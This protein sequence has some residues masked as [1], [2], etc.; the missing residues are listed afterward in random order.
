MIERIALATDP[1]FSVLL[2][3]PQGSG[4]VG[5]VLVA[6]HG[7]GQ[8]A[9]E[10]CQAL[11]P[12]AASLGYALACPQFPYPGSTGAASQGYMYLSEPGVDYLGL[13][14]AVIASAWQFA[15]SP[16]GAIDLLGFSAGG[17]AAHRYAFLKPE[18]VRMAC[19]VSPGAITLPSSD[20]AWWNGIADVADRFGVPFNPEGVRRVVFSLL[21]GA[22][23]TE[24]S[25]LSYVPGQPIERLRALRTGHTRVERLAT[26]HD[27]LL[28]FGAPS[29]L[30]IVDGAGHSFRQLLPAIEAAFREQRPTA[31]AR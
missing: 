6:L 28:E 12:L 16:P 5:R 22:N 7:I 17:Q 3:K 14:D 1:R 24:T 8:Q 13:M 19:I 20:A 29:S 9:D 23:D 25:G 11:Q 27:A 26:L 15:G 18:R 30:S 4:R 10:V 31:S 21:V 2:H